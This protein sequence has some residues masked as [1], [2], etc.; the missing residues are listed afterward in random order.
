MRELCAVENYSDDIVKISRYQLEIVSR[1]FRSRARPVALSSIMSLMDET[2]QRNTTS[3]YDD[4]QQSASFGE[5]WWNNAQDQEY[6]TVPG[7][8]HITPL[9]R[10]RNGSQSNYMNF[11]FTYQVPE[12]GVEILLTTKDITDIKA[13]CIF[14][15]YEIN[16]NN[17]LTQ[18]LYSAAGSRFEEEFNENL[19]KFEG[20]KLVS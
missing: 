9:T 6:T 12:S 3:N 11:E 5:N 13:D 2:G 18:H 4:Y 8:E 1:H 19:V 20:Q 15:Y 16:A 10:P 14:N 17:P 7:L